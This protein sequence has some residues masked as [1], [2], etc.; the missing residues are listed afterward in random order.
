M[1]GIK[2]SVPMS[3]TFARN[4]EGRVHSA[5]NSLNNG[6]GQSV[7]NLCD[8]VGA[9]IT[10]PRVSDTCAAIDRLHKF[11]RMRK[12]TDAYKL[13]RRKSRQRK[14]DLYDSKHHSTKSNKRT[15]AHAVLNAEPLTHSLSTQDN[16]LSGSRDSDP[17]PSTSTG[18]SSLDLEPIPSTSTGRTRQGNNISTPKNSTGP[19]E[20]HSYSQASYNKGAGAFELIQQISVEYGEHERVQKIALEYTENEQFPSFVVTTKR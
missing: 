20:D 19:P 18:R 15:N 3:L 2:K 4:Y 13:V 16:D 11:D 1:R 5:I 6:V 17:I 14:Y 9:P 8:Y 12:K 7:V 10:S